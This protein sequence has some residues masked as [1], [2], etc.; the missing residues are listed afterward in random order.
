MSQPIS[1]LLG[2][3]EEQQKIQIQKRI[4][5]FPEISETRNNNVQ[6]QEHHDT[7]KQSID[8]QLIQLSVVLDECFL[9][10]DATMYE[11]QG[12][13]EELIAMGIQIVRQQQDV[14]DVTTGEVISFNTLSEDGNEFIKAV[15]LERISEA[16]GKKK[17]NPTINSEPEITNK[18][19]EE[20]D[21]LPF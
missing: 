9:H 15:L 10:P 2:L 14:V 12:R 18:P 7:D 11:L 17:D 16:R 20:D 4:D 6:E 5:E 3:D 1:S 13:E 21:D 19:D 8:E